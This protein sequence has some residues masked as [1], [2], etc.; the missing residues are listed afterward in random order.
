MAGVRVQ[1]V[2]KLAAIASPWLQYMI[3]PSCS[4]PAHMQCSQLAYTMLIVFGLTHP[5]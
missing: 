1:G 5:L 4:A 2:F 3:L